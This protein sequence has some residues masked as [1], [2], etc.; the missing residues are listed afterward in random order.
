MS[1]TRPRKSSFQVLGRAL[2]SWL[3]ILACLGAGEALAILTAK[4]GFA[5]PGSVIG[6][7][8]LFVL[9][10]SGVVRLERVVGAAGLLLEY[11]GLF[12]VPAGVALIS[13]W[14]ELK[15]CWLAVLVAVAASTLLVL[16]GTGTVANQF[17]RDADENR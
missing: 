11:L 10:I 14:Q 4:A 7:V 3:L 9:L 1:Q 8:L 2:F 13:R 17:K 12:F 5:L 16:W 15:S 6:M